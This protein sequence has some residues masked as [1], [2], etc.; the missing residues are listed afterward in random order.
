MI[1]K[2]K[3]NKYQPYNY[4]NNKLE[5]AYRGK[6]DEKYSNYYQG[7][8][9][10]SPVYKSNS[11]I[12]TDYKYSDNIYENNMYPDNKYESYTNDNYNYEKKNY[13]DNKYNEGKYS[14]E[15]KIFFFLTFLKVY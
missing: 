6:K 3:E 15:C 12:Y 14:K 1:Y 11:P 13:K 10:E 8:S 4:K 2:N 5:G 7:S 9:Y